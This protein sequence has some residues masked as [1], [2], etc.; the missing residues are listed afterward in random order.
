MPKT[1]HNVTRNLREGGFFEHADSYVDTD[2][3]LHLEGPDKSKIRPRIFK[4]YKNRCC[5]CGTP[6]SETAPKFHPRAGAY[7]HPGNPPCDC[8]GCG[9]LRCDQTTGR[10]C[11]DHSAPGFKRD[12]EDAV[13][14]FNKLYPPES[15]HET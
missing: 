11:H 8:V 6:L 4:R 7:H 15:G 10:P 13:R 5:V 3:H 2:G 14:E 9:E 12:K 1:D